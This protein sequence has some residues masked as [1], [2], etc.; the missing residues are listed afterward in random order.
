[1]VWMNDL[2]II[3]AQLSYYD[4][5]TVNIGTVMAVKV[6]GKSLLKG[7]EVV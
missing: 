1:M 5:V 4:L 3:E 7:R 2:R 6:K